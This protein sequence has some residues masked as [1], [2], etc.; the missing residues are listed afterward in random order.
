MSKLILSLLILSFSSSFAMHDNDD[1]DNVMASIDATIDNWTSSTPDTYSSSNVDYDS[2]CSTPSD[3]TM[4]SMIDNT[5]DS[6]AN[7]Q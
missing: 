4:D 1:N 3:S 7:K 6:A 5:I 2:F